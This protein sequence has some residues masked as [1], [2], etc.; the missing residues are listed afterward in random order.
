MKVTIITV[1]GIIIKID[2]MVDED[3]YGEDGYNSNDNDDI[4]VI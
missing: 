4:V 1:I 3:D 2:D